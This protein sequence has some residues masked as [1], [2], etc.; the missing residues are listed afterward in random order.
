MYCIK[1]QSQLK[2]VFFQNVFNVNNFT[3]IAVLQ[4]LINL[5]FPKVCAAC[6][7][8]LLE[9]ENII[10]TSCRHEMPTTNHYLDLDND[11]FKLFYGRVDVVFVATLFYFQKQSLVQEM[12]Y[13]LKYR[14]NQDVGTTL[15]FWMGSNLKPLAVTSAKRSAILPNVPT[16]A[17][18]GVTGISGR[19]GAPDLVR[20]AARRQEIDGRSVRRRSRRWRPARCRSRWPAGPPRRRQRSTPRRP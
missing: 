12:I 19:V 20:P 13:S 2:K 15:G 7:N 1:N 6:K 11:A 14:G 18:A 9:A 8:I 17:E 16:M 10:C 4:H 5:V 3:A